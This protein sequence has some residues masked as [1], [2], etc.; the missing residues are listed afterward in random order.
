MGFSGERL[1]NTAALWTKKLG[2][3]L[4]MASDAWPIVDLKSENNRLFLYKGIRDMVQRQIWGVR[5]L[6]SLNHGEDGTAS[7]GSVAFSHSSVQWGA[8]LLQHW[9]LLVWR[10][11]GVYGHGNWVG[12]NA[13]RWVPKQLLNPWKME[14]LADHSLGNLAHIWRCDTENTLLYSHW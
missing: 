7:N 11:P 3:H 8:K 12:L 14:H 1:G 6:N 10:F 5:S 9:P 13:L 2:T 4:Q